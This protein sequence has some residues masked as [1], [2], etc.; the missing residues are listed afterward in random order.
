MDEI[1]EDSD[2]SSDDSGEDISD[3]DNANDSASER[4]TSSASGNDNNAAT[5]KRGDVKLRD[6]RVCSKKGDRKDTRYYVF[7]ILYYCKACNV[8]LCQGK[9]FEVFHSQKDYS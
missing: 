6:I 1:N 9:C 8:P 7:I 4:N 2:E 3:A 5:A